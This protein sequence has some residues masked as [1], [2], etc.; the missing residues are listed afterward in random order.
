MTPAGKPLGTQY[1][2]LQ[3]CRL[4]DG[5]H[6]FALYAALNAL[7]MLVLGRLVVR[8][9]V[10]TQTPIGDGGKPDMAGPLRAHGNNT[11]WTPMAVVMM[12]VLVSLG[13]PWWLIHVV[14]VPLTAGRL[15][16]GA[17]LQKNTGTSQL[18]SIGMAADLARLH[19]RDRCDLLDPVLPGHDHAVARRSA[20]TWRHG[21]ARRTFSAVC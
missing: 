7:I 16:H 11:E 21:R 20:V 17:A 6:I 19:L 1:G 8:A 10:K 4:T 9:R 18:R 5:Y 13:G 12:L 15:L 2:H 3:H 14:G